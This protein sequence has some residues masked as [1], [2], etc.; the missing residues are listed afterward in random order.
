MNL[1]TMFWAYREASGWCPLSASNRRQGEFGIAVSKDYDALRWQRYDRL[2]RKL[3]RRLEADFDAQT[4]HIAALE[5]ELRRSRVGLTAPTHAVNDYNCEDW[6]IGQ[7]CRGCDGD[8][9]REAIVNEIDALLPKDADD[10]APALRRLQT[11]R[12]YEQQTGNP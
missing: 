8:E 11:R 1:R 10:A 4:E 12:C 7:G 6:P 5:A 2:M 9:L 3:Q